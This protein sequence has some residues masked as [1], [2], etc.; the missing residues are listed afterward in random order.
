MKTFII[1]FEFDKRNYSDNEVDNFILNLKKNN[2]N[3]IYC[4]I[5]S[6]K[7]NLIYP[8]IIYIC[9][10][11]FCFL[12]VIRSI[13]MYYDYIIHL[14]CLKYINFDKIIKTEYNNNLI[15]V[16]NDKNHNFCRIIPKNMVSELNNS[17]YT[18][19]N[20][21][22]INCLY[23]ETNLNI[24][25]IS[26]NDD[27]DIFIQGYEKSKDLISIIMTCYNS[28]KTIDNAIISIL[29]QTY[30]ALELVIVDDCST[31]NTF[32]IIEKYKDLDDRI[33]VIKLNENSGCYYAKNIGLKNINKNTNYI[34]FQDSDDISLASR[35]YKQHDFM[36]RNKL[37]LTTCLFY[38]DG[39]LKMPMISKMFTINVFN[40]LGYFGPKRF[41]EDEHYYNRFFCLF[42]KNHRWNNSIV[43]NSNNI[44]YF[45]NH[46][47]YRNI[48]DILYIVNRQENSL[49]KVYKN[50][51]QFSEKMI[52]YYAH[53][54]KQ[55][56][57]KIKHKCFYSLKYVNSKIEEYK[58][59]KEKIET[60]INEDNSSQENVISEDYDS[61]ENNYLFDESIKQV[62]ISE[63]L[64]HLKKRFLEKYKLRSFYSFNKPCLFFGLYSEKDIKILSRMK[65]KKYVIWGG[66]DLDLDHR[67]RYHN[68]KKIM[69]YGID[70]N[71]A[72]SNNLEK[73]MQSY[74]MDYKRINFSLLD[75]NSFYPISIKGPNIFIYNG[76]N[77]GNEEI[78]GKKIYE[79]VIDLLPEYNF[80]LSNKLKI[81]NNK[82]HEIYK[83]CFIGLRLTQKDGNANMVE[84]LIN[85]NIPIVHNGDYDKA[86]PWNDIISIITAIKKNIPKILI[87]FEKDMNLHDGSLIWLNNFISLI[88]KFYVNTKII[89]Y[90]KVLDPSIKIDNVTF[91]DNL[92]SYNYDHIFFRIMDK[93]IK[94]EKYENV[95]L[96]I[97]KFE[98]NNIQYYKKF[99]YVIAQSILIKDE[100]LFNS[101]DNVQIL[102]PLISK[103]N[104]NEKSNKISFCY[105]GTIKKQYQSLEL[106]QLFD[107][108]S[109]R[110]NF[111]FNLIYG[112]IKKNNSSYD[113][114]LLDLIHKLKNNNNFNIYYD[115]E[116]YK[117]NEILKTTHYGIVIHSEETDFKQQSTKLIE[118][119]GE[120]CIPITYLSFLNS[121]YTNKSL[122]FRSI[123]D[124]EDI[125]INIFK[126][127]INYYDINI[128]YDKLK[129]HLIE[130]NSH[131]FNQEYKTYITDK[132]VT[133]FNK[134]I[135]T[136]NYQ[137]LFLNKN[138]IFTKEKNELV[139]IRN[140]LE[141]RY[142]KYDKTYN[143][144][145]NFFLKNDSNFK[146]NYINSIFNHNLHKDFFVLNEVNRKDNIYKF[147]NNESYIEFNCFLEKKNTYNVT[148]NSEVLTEGI[149]FLLS[150][151]DVN[152]VL[153]DINRNV[154][155]VK[156][157]NSNLKFIVNP[158]NDANYIFKLIPSKRNTNLLSVKI[159][160]FEIDKQVS[161]NK[162]C[163]KI[164]VINMDKHINKFY[165]IYNT[166]E[167]NGIICERE[168][169]VNGQMEKLKT[170]F[171]IY[172]NTP[173][174]EKEIKLGRKLIVSSGAIGYL[175]SMLNI[176]KD[177]ITKNY[178]YI[179]I[180]DDD[181]RLIDD[182]T[183]NF[184]KLYNTLNGKYR[185]L[186][187][188]SSQWDWDN[189]KF[190][191]NYYY[192]NESSNG[193]FAN[194]YHRST[195][196]QIYNKVLYFTHPFDDEPMKSNFIK[197]YC[198]VSYPN[199]IIAQL[200]ESSI[201]EKKSS[202]SYERFKW[203]KDN[204]HF[205][206]LKESSLIKKENILDKNYDLHFVIGI[207]TYNRCKY[208]Q[209]CI[210]S[211]L[212]SL[213]NKINYTLIIAD[214]NS[215][216]ETNK[217][218][219]NLILPNNISLI[220]I[221]NEKHF[222][223]RQ[224]NSILKY[225][226][227]LD[228]NI[229]FLINDDIIFKKKGWDTSYYDAC[230]KTNFD[231]L[232]YFD[233][234]FKKQDHYNY[235]K[236]LQSYCKPQNCQ[237]A[238]FTF[239]KRLINKIGFFDEENFKIRGHSHIDFTL[240]CC[241]LNF[242]DK[243]YLF[244]ILNSDDYLE[245]NNQDYIS[246]FVKL[247]YQ[248]R[249]LYK[250]DIY[251][252]DKRNKI[253]NNESRILIKS[254][255]IFS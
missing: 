43:Y 36:K 18:D 162:I 231:H 120:G 160:N 128:N 93:N 112:K 228:F 154:H 44:G 72:I 57:K 6:K 227:M 234:K 253:L 92:T 188:G 30:K 204:Y 42:S 10:S 138:V 135:I 136:D 35:I 54:N 181:I 73:R 66:T 202:R 146:I 218:I 22:V 100:L 7:V 189:I 235:N 153:K 186:L 28:E 241:R 221:N 99:K 151:T 207:V 79:N 201:R 23:K 88:Q 233:P 140:L 122:S 144:T 11:K 246:S 232:V 149:L 131:I 41:G 251:E 172:N 224:S 109:N 143:I 150:I 206:P 119:L 176:F 124:L 5:S 179:M 230:D 121:N 4:V 110:Y 13:K 102:P 118:Y 83:K 32:K 27:N 24:N 148:F 111:E 158:K 50:R 214:G 82:M 63:S 243:Y 67:N 113:M 15:Y 105:C 199:L 191:S 240:R 156:N 211:L 209:K 9:D 47:F 132:T 255:I 159:I 61:Y 225:A 163:D 77:E 58:K 51:K 141:N 197:N 196:E 236:Y 223:Y 117:I 31:D 19:N 107:K 116:K 38:E 60:N 29:N 242:N 166:F 70:I 75:E 95:T 25:F 89:V 213:N 26:Q 190:K 178:K 17:Y 96:V 137:N 34:T 74:K 212:N 106:L 76:Y 87:I 157:S 39:I 247:P 139:N 217:Y 180:C 195:F 205:T 69:N 53:L 45:S 170:Q 80:I 245:L 91:V 200:E 55:P 238:F 173:F 40:S 244:D 168:L 115:I 185:L 1:L 161:L 101:I 33:K 16:S 90:C 86:I 71:Y 104:K 164:K 78:Y 237:G 252:Q 220:L 21:E 126:D 147:Y 94:F 49:T 226:E 184:N 165:D 56:L 152:G 129:N 229:G 134:I 81:P 48:S 193:S 97:H 84:E 103:I 167:N 65:N 114:K 3:F 155:F 210:S 108:L 145:T 169:G 46:K 250:V 125:I 177:A 37:F 248:L 198:Y 14:R 12:N 98:L 222:I 182:F 208:L 142:L 123:E 130:N 20:F 203:N 183:S 171:E 239:T 127:T 59:N 215:H 8:D 192:P 52:T 133:N 68:F 175:Y 219:N 64:K 174:N 187:L 254:N 216:D 194:I 2:Y 85:M 62:Y 249:E